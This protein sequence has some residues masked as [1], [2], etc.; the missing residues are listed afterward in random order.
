V[1]RT[2]SNWSLEDRASRKVPRIEANW[3][4]IATHRT[5]PSPCRLNSA[6]LEREW[7]KA[8]KVA[9]SS[10]H[11]DGEA[12]NITRRPHVPLGL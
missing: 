5:I 3:S 9:F 11:E 7:A 8:P 1:L 4:V 12:G 10:I 2:L 6:R